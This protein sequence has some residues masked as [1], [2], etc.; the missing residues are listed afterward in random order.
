MRVFCELVLSFLAWILIRRGGDISCEIDK[1]FLSTN[2]FFCLRRDISK[3]FS[4][5]FTLHCAG[6]IRL[7]LEKIFPPT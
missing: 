5:K 7:T 3:N 1:I 4:S 6:K 2:L